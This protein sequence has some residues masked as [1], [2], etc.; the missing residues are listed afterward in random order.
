MIDDGPV[1]EAA[2]ATQ[3]RNGLAATASGYIFIAISP[4]IVAGAG[5]HGVAMAFWRSWVG[6]GVLALV[7]AARRKLTWDLVM[8]TAPAGLSFGVS[9]GLF[10]WASQLTSIANVSLIVVLQPIPMMIAAH[11]M[12][13]EH[14]ARRD[15]ALSTVAI[16]G[17]I[18]LVLVSTSA[19]TGDTK[20]DALALVSIT[21][22]AGY[23]AFSKRCLESMSVLRFMVGMFAW[24]GVA[25][26]PMVLIS[27]E[28]IVPTT[29][30]DWLRVLGVASLPGV[31]HILLNYAH[32][33]V[34]LNMMGVLQLLIPVTATLLAFW[35]LGQSVSGL[36]ILGMAVVMATLA[37]H[38]RTRFVD[39]SDRKEQSDR[40][41]RPTLS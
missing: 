12:F 27:G 36:Q 25:L 19:G 30:D 37:V 2:T 1:P 22:G 23:F 39:A 28:S 29:G 8:P 11:Y 18:F 38:A 4:V 10:F 5:V 32:G 26:T 34:P 14:I 41:E 15:L 16:G 24:A 6:F 33:K 31:G 3:L 40:T 9:I 35:F 21:I 20:G 7:A 17:S 13:S